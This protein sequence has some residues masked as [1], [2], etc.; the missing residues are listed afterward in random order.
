MVLWLSCG[1]WIS[2]CSSQLH[3]LKVEWLG[4]RSWSL[5]FG[6]SVWKRGA[7]VGPPTSSR[8]VCQ[9][10][11]GAMSGVCLLSAVLSTSK[12]SRKPLLVTSL[13]CWWW[14]FWWMARMC[15]WIGVILLSIFGGVLHQGGFHSSK[16]SWVESISLRGFWMSLVTKHV[17][18]EC[19]ASARSRVM[20]STAVRWSPL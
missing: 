7:R 14:A 20:C 16:K 17:M 11:G 15:G 9:C 19:G 12:V 6:M 18:V 3:R 10:H 1:L 2:G 4:L 8:I 5:V 13:H